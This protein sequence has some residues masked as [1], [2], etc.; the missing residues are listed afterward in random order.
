MG[1]TL[2][3]T[4]KRGA[5]PS[6]LT[7]GQQTFVA[8][9]L[10]NNLF[11]ARAAAKAAGYKQPSQSAYKMLKNPKIQALLG[12]AMRE[13]ME[14]C[15]LK[16]DDVLNYLRTALFFNPLNYFKPTK[17]GKW[18]IDDPTTLPE[19]VG[20][21]IEKMEVRT[22]ELKDG[23]VHSYFKIE[24]VS[25]TT[26]LSLAMKHVGLTVDE[27]STRVIDWDKLYQSGNGEEVDPIEQQILDA[28][29]EVA[30]D[31]SHG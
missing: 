30:D 6:L 13:R 4:R 14:R 10:A 8:E 25:K 18:M 31:E 7:V 11:D 12:K 9:L 3:K 27:V 21:L 28:E 19:E 20:R 2:I 1:T 26:A 15:Q 5:D 17:D 16:S 22:T 29:F 23:S 24:L